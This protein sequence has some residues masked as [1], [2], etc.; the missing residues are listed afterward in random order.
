MVQILPFL[1]WLAAITSAVLLIV[2]W[3]LGELRR[4]SV[5]VLLGWFLLAAYCQ[6]L[7][8]SAIVG[9]V[10]LLFQTIL[11]IYLMLRWKLS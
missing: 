7:A 4:L 10:G 2:L 6:F 11:A 1:A 8:A 3:R 5:G 9:S